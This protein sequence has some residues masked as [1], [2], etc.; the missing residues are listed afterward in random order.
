MLRCW[1]TA[2]VVS[3]SYSLALSTSDLAWLLGHWRPP[4]READAKPGQRRNLLS[5]SSA[6]NLCGA[7][8]TRASFTP[9]VLWSDEALWTRGEVPQ[10]DETVSLST[11]DEEPRAQIIVNTSTR[12]GAVAL[13]GNDLTMVLGAPLILSGSNLPIQF[14]QSSL[15]PYPTTSVTALPS[16]DLSS[17]NTPSGRPSDEPSASARSLC[18]ADAIWINSFHHKWGDRAAWVQER[19]PNRTSDLVRVHSTSDAHLTIET[20]VA[21]GA[22]ALSVLDGGSLVL[23][24]NATL[25][26]SGLRLT[27][28]QVRSQAV[29][30]R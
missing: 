16:A 26:L 7:D 28:L 8:A 12:A 1:G 15:A 27:Q 11:T 14:C 30:C 19:P 6:V 18:D 23:K 20:P 9:A 24:L 17:L 21:V 4:L 29:A 2:L 10:D 13:H 22:L 25:S 3:L 5:S